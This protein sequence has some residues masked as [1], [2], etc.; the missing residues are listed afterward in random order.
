[1]CYSNPSILLMYYYNNQIIYNVLYIITWT[2]IWTIPLYLLKLHNS[3]QN[4]IFL[5]ETILYFSSKSNPRRSPT[6]TRHPRRLP[7]TTRHPRVR[8]ARWHRAICANR[9]SSGVASWNPRRV[10]P[11]SPNNFAKASM[12]QYISCLSYILREPNIVREKIIFTIQ[13][14][15]L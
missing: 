2:I 12:F 6:P 3:Y 15:L 11:F 13:L 8:Q 5:L 9:S 4:T 1:M 7:T 10:W 14:L